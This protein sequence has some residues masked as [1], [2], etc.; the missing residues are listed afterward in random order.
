MILVL[1]MEKTIMI[2]RKIMKK[3]KII[4]RLVK[5]DEVVK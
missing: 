5:F 4:C 2:L 3:M 1:I